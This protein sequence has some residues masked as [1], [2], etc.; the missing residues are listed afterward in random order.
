MSGFPVSTAADLD[1]KTTVHSNSNET[2]IKKFLPPSA[3]KIYAKQVLMHKAAAE[4][5]YQ[6]YQAREAE[7]PDLQALYTE[8]NAAIHAPKRDNAIEAALQVQIDAILATWK[9]ED[10]E[11][12]AQAKADGATPSALGILEPAIRLD[13]K[14]K[15]VAFNYAEDVP[16]GKTAHDMVHEC[17]ALNTALQDKR[18]A[19]IKAPQT[20]GETAALFAAEVDRI[21]A[22][23][24]TNIKNVKYLNR[25]DDR[26]RFEQ[27]VFKMP[28]AVV[29]DGVGM[30]LRIPDGIAL[31]CLLFPQE[32]VAR[33]TELADVD[34]STAMNRGDR[35]AALDDIDAQILANDR[36]GEHFIR[37]CQSKNI[38]GG[39]RWTQDIRAILDI[40]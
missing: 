6:R 26:G 20:S 23:A 39:S 8:L 7:K 21:A 14:E 17:R 12:D 34:D 13:L 22:R 36:R 5:A 28:S 11:W 31:S 4:L 30:A 3:Q 37:V 1:R 38:P 9:A 10:E 29:H 40:H 24:L 16:E 19:I 25:N 15:R 2:K 33:L 32:I 27:Q 18:K 35:E